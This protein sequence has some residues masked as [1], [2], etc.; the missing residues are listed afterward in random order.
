[1][2]IGNGTVME[3]RGRWIGIDYGDKRT[4]VSLSDPT[5]TIATGLCV[6]RGLDDRELIEKIATLAGERDAVGVV[7]GYPLNM[8]GSR[9]PRAVKTEEFMER[10]RE[11]LPVMVVGQDE[12]LTTRQS[13]RVI[14]AHGKKVRKGGKI[15]QI[16]AVLILQGYLDR[17]AIASPDRELPL[18][19]GSDVE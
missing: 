2:D 7:V 6:F 1:M 3:F 14:H 12:R 17:N 15:D 4:G 13:A 18:A 16:S 9:G 19:D 10:L 5:A 8:N 11:E